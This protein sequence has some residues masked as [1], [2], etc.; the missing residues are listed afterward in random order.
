MRKIFFIALSAVCFVAAAQAQ[1]V[2]SI[3]KADNH[4]IA[5]TTAEIRKSEI[6][7]IAFSAYYNGKSWCI[8]FLDCTNFA[9][10]VHLNTLFYR[11]KTCYHTAE[12]DISHL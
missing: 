2:V 7:K 11:F 5:Y 1:K 4:T 3:S 6:N 12:V 8:K 9:I 10:K